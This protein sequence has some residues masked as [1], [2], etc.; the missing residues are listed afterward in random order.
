MA[1]KQSLAPTSATGIVHDASASYDRYPH[2][3]T[4]SGGAAVTITEEYVLKR[5]RTKVHEWSGLN[6]TD[7]LEL[8]HNALSRIANYCSKEELRHFPK[9]LKYLAGEYLEETN[10]GKVLSD[11]T[12]AANMTRSE[13]M[14]QIQ[15]MLKCMHRASVWHLDFYT[16]PKYCKNIAVDHVGSKI[17]LI[18]FDISVVGT[19][20]LT[21]L[22]KKRLD[23]Y[24]GRWSLYAKHFTKELL[25]CVL[26]ERK[27]DIE[28]DPNAKCQL[29]NHSVDESLANDA[30]DWACGRGV[31]D[32]K[33]LESNFTNKSFYEITDI[34]LDVFYQ[35]VTRKTGTECCFGDDDG[36]SNCIARLK[37]ED[38]CKLVPQFG[39]DYPS[40][41][42]VKKGVTVNDI[43]GA[44]K[45]ACNDGHV[46]CDSLNLHDKAFSLDAAGIVFN[47]YYQCHSRMSHAC[48]F[49]TNNN[50]SK[51][52]MAE[53]VSRN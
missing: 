42:V 43:I 3:H 2:P 7:A 34:I 38:S 50:G 53:A 49:H 28:L 11:P 20:P 31:I 36:M 18:D 8:E 44:V 52:C 12:A 14:L 13:A 23:K 10:E 40:V 51:T 24:K 30:V 16:P 26:G 17:S 19:E 41:C 45:W 22:I 48:C 25:K 15:A 32:C 21:P 46:D 27:K 37:Y 9:V 29:K 4:T 1:E 35:N 5:A 33:T 47:S 6:G 39:E